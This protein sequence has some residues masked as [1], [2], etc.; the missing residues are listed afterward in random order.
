MWN[1]PHENDPPF[2][3]A[4]KI[5][6]DATS[7]YAFLINVVLLSEKEIVSRCTNEEIIFLKN[8]IVENI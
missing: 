3:F 8:T 4:K 7:L 5:Y 2:H 1:K 6:P